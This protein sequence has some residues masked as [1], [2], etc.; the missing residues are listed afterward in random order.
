ME[1]DFKLHSMW[2]YCV[3]PIQNKQHFLRLEFSALVHGVDFSFSFLI[4]V[5]F[6]LAPVVLVTVQHCSFQK[7]LLWSFL[8]KGFFSVWNL[9]I[10]ICTKT[11]KAGFFLPW[12]KMIPYDDNNYLKEKRQ[13]VLEQVYRYHQIWTFL[14]KNEFTHKPIYLWPDLWLGLQK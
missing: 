9:C 6:F 10:W 13:P 1:T 11:I 3:L 5:I 4:I 12:R 7:Q 2:K 8:S 14:A